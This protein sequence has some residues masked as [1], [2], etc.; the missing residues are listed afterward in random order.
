MPAC[1]R[2]ESTFIGEQVTG[3]TCF[4]EW[5]PDSSATPQICAQPLIWAELIYRL[6]HAVIHSAGV[7]QFNHSLYAGFWACVGE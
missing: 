5:P 3:V 2:V 6:A 4:Q 7:C 1:P